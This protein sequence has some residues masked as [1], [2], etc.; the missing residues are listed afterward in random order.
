[1]HPI[2]SYF[3]LVSFLVVRRDHCS[4][5]TAVIPFCA[6]EW[7]VVVL[8]DHVMPGIELG[9]V[10]RKATTYFLPQLSSPVR[11]ILVQE[12][13]CLHT[14]KPGLVF[15]TAHHPPRTAGCLLLSEVWPCVL[16]LVICPTQSPLVVWLVCNWADIDARHAH[17]PAI[18]FSEQD[19]SAWE[20]T[21][22]RD[23][24]SGCTSC[25]WKCIFP[26][27]PKLGWTS[28]AAVWKLPANPHLDY[29][30]WGLSYSLPLPPCL[31]V[32][33]HCEESVKRGAQISAYGPGN[34]H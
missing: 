20:G 8:R 5:Q 19:C 16:E 21:L 15:S 17:Q 10:T 1:M 28:F 25:L 18:S 14:A 34:H 3:V 27:Q 33:A 9:S 13:R 22:F 7:P 23:W 2:A 30:P 12:I 29:W 4:A 32:D 31:A 24:N 26:A 6:Q 11:C